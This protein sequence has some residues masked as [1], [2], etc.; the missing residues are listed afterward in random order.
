MKFFYSLLILLTV[1]KINSQDRKTIEA[2]RFLN[3]PLIDGIIS[4]DEW[5]KTTPAKDFTLF[6][7]QIRA[8]EKIPIQYETVVNFGSVSYT[9]LTLPTKA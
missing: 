4:E 7:P 8:G 9:H 3:P 1:F 2:Y 5:K 6:K